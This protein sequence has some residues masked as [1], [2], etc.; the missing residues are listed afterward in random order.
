MITAGMLNQPTIS[1]FLHKPGGMLNIDRSRLTAMIRLLFVVALR[2]FVAASLAAGA[3]AAEPPRVGIE[4][5]QYS[6]A[7][8]LP[9]SSYGASSLNF[10][11]GPVAFDTLGDSIFIVGHAHHQAIAEFALPALVNSQVLGDLNMA[12]A[13]VQVF[14]GVL[15]RATSGNPQNINR[16]GGLAVINHNGAR[17]LVINGY[18]YY[19]A[20][21]SVT[22]TTAVLP[23]PD[24]LAGSVVRGYFS[25][26]GGAGHT[27]GWLSPIPEFWQDA[28]GGTFITGQSS[29]IP[30][31]SR[32]SVGPSAFA[33]DPADLINNPA[34]T[35]PVQTSKLLDF[36]LTN[37]LHTDLSNQSL[38]NDLWT[39][40]S[41]AVFGFIVPGTSTYLT[42]G[43]SGGHGSGVCYKCTQNNNN[44][45]G[46]YCA[47]DADD[48]SLY[49]W[50]WD[51]N[52]LAQVRAGELAAHSV[53]PYDYGEFVA[54]FATKQLGG[55]SFD[56]ASGR[57]FLTMQRADR[58]QGTYANPPV[59]LVYEL[60]VDDV[61]PSKAVPVP[62]LLVA[63]G[64]FMLV[65]TYCSFV[66]R[67]PDGR[68]TA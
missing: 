46:G 25:F 47:P 11:Q 27:S 24:D 21:A 34:P 66:L 36:S 15:N 40:L 35:T 56:A 1:C 5:L 8:R 29:G 16:I 4:V 7:F 26:A 61:V 31:I 20:D 30:I 49:Y 39:H 38:D 44:L 33:F 3:C 43:Y 2:L 62:V 52:D 19:D 51:V 18:E 59:V 42:L 12:S 14:A 9:A 37:P 41:R 23:D 54:P 48:Y 58:D 68:G 55:G 57:V 17:E 45:C 10:S 6:G 53:R 50:L 65:V 64:G 60:D 22:H 63:L 28:L 13:P 32:T 67:R